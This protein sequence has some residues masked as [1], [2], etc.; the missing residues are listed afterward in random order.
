MTEIHLTAAWVTAQMAGAIAVGD[1]MREFG[2]VSIDSRTLKS[3]DLFIAI[4]GDRFDGVAFADA[5]IDAGAA[6]VVVPRGWSHGAGERSAHPGGATGRSASR[7]PSARE[8]SRKLRGQAGSVAGGL[9]RP[10]R[11][12][13]PP[14]PRP[15]RRRG[16]G[17]PSRRP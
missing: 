12:C 17:R 5:A 14:S 3:G 1:Q 15:L 6:G 16:G 7:S 13:R 9:N 2:D 8:E 10:R 4:R 11:R